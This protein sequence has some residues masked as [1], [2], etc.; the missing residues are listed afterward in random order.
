MENVSL[1]FEIFSIFPMLKLYIFRLIGILGNL[2]TPQ[3]FRK[4]RSTTNH[5]QQGIQIAK[6]LPNREICFAGHN[7]MFKIP[8]NPT[9]AEELREAINTFILMLSH[10]RGKPSGYFQTI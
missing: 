3:Q 10:L 5:S 9:R 1:I 7:L 2:D 4:K 8:E 6:I